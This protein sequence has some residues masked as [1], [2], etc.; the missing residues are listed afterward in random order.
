M[1]APFHAAED[2]LGEYAPLQYV[3]L[4]AYPRALKTMLPPLAAL[5]SNHPTS[6]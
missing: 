1:P 5:V 4:T 6:A 3:P 2:T